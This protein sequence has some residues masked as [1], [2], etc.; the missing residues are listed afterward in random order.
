MG[1]SDKLSFRGYQCVNCFFWE[2]EASSEEICWA[3]EIFYKIAALHRT[4]DKMPDDVKKSI[5]VDIQF[6]EDCV[7]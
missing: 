5:E 4:Y 6:A 1:K 7:G 2:K 3:A